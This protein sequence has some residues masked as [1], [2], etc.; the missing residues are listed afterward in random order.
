V[1]GTGSRIRFIAKIAPVSGPG[2]GGGKIVVFEY[3]LFPAAGIRVEK[4]VDGVAGVVECIDSPDAIDSSMLT[5]LIFCLHVPGVFQWPDDGEDACQYT[6]DSQYPS[7]RPFLEKLRVGPFFQ[8]PV[9]EQKA[10][11]TRCIVYQQ[12]DGHRQVG[13]GKEFYT[14]IESEVHKDDVAHD[15]NHKDGAQCCRPSE[16]EKN[17]RE[18]L[19]A[20]DEKFIPE[21]ISKEGPGDRHGAH[22]GDSGDH[23]SDAW[24]ELYVEYFGGAVL[25]DNVC[26]EEAKDDLQYIFKPGIAV[27]LLINDAPHYGQEESGAAGDGEK[28]KVT[29]LVT[30]S[31]AVGDKDVDDDSG[32]E[33]GK[34]FEADVFYPGSNDRHVR[35]EFS[36]SKIRKSRIRWT[37][38]AFFY[39]QAIL[40]F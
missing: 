3:E 36:G 1:Q 2:F 32:E 16:E 24:R 33:E 21:G 8:G 22:V 4:M 37:D 12:V 25:S 15:G 17:G 28:P 40:I 11:Q 13:A 7:G 27:S 6:N 18:D 31:I 38:P 23:I 9:Q 14:Y 20:A 35:L 39:N 5:N 19:T 30:A 26:E 29:R 34:C 10:G